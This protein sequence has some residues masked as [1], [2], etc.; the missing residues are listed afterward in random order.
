MSE[1]IQRLQARRSF[2][3][4]KVKSGTAT[5]EER[6]EYERTRGVHVTETPH[7]VVYIEAP[8]MNAQEWKEAVPKINAEHAERMRQDDKSTGNTG[9]NS[10]P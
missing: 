7:G 2:L 5:A 1:Y 9:V 3:A 8:T 10:T 6:A 4:L